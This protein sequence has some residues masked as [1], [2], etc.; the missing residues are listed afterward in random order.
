MKRFFKYIIIAFVALSTLGLESCSIQRKA[1]QPKE[2][3]QILSLDKVKGNLKEGIK[4]T[5]TVENNTA[6]NLQVTEATAFLMYN[7]KKIGRVALNGTVALPRR[8]TTQV[9]APLRITLSGPLA[10]ISAINNFRKGNFTGFTIDVNATV[11]TRCKKR[12]IE[13]KGLTFDELAQQFN[14]KLK[15]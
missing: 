12:T 14:I 3:L 2:K 7:G 13:R 11:A 15:K 1:S 8:A 5:I 10:S 6:F 9:V 4:A